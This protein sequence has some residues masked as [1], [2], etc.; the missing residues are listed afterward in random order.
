MNSKN[1]R[2]LVSL[3]LIILL[4]VVFGLTTDSFLSMRN[5]LQLFRDAAYAGLVACGVVFV[6]VGG[7][8]DLSVGGLICVIGIVV[9]R[10]SQLTWMPGIAVILVG[11]LAGAACGLL[12]GAIV[13]R[14][15]MTEFVTTLASGAVFTGLA[16]LLQFR[17]AGRMISVTLTNRGFLSW[18]LDIGGIYIII[19][20]WLVLTAVMQFLMSST[21]FGLHV[22]SIGSHTKSAEMSGV[23]TR[24]TKVL[25]FMIS[26][27]F[28]GLAAA[29]IVAYQTGTN[30]TL[31]NMMEFNAIAACVVGGVVLGGGKGDPVSGFLGALLMALIT[32]G[33][34]KWGLSTGGTYVMQ[35]LVI[36]LAMNFDGQFNRISQKRL[37]LRG[38]L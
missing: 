36:L 31:G 29:M 15:H 25:T 18:G 6:M 22:M 7:G 9:A 4:C 21:R 24:R 13:T 34:Y 30:Q 19:I 11:I 3:A 20:V 16:L 8:I 5:M 2:R 14:L 37:E 28:A 26:G 17:D 23:N 10:F 12:N 38:R 32:N 27:A 1:T 35:G 33:L